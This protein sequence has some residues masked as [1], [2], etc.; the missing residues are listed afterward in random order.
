MDKLLN[1][2]ESANLSKE[3]LQERGTA[4]AITILDDG[5]AEVLE[6]YAMSRKAIEYLTAFNKGLDP[7]ARE[8]VSHGMDVDA[9]GVNFSLSSTGDRIDY[10]VDEVYLKL[11][12][13]VKDREMLLKVAK[14]AEEYIFDGNGDKVPRLPL[15]S[16]SKEILRVKL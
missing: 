10:E 15:K 4:D 16:A 14:H 7:S 8:E 5:L 1:L 12:K 11:K 3:E 2:D 6:M 13:A 9:L